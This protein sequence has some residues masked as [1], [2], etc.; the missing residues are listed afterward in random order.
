MS[1]KNK[2]K[3]RT[4]EP[5][6]R[7]DPPVEEDYEPPRTVYKATLVYLIDQDEV[8]MLIQASTAEYVEPPVPVRDEYYTTYEEYEVFQLL[9][10]EPITLRKPKKRK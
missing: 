4:R 5:E 8:N 10:G 2:N 7:Y 1:K 9:N 6:D 3:N